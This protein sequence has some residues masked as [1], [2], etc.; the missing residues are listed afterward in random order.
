[1]LSV[2][3]TC[4]WC[5]THVFSTNDSLKNIEERL[6]RSLNVDNNDETTV[7]FN[8]KNMERMLEKA[9]LKII[10]GNLS[11]GDMLLLKS[12]NY[13]LEEVLA[14]REREL[15]KKIDDDLQNRHKIKPK[16]KLSRNNNHTNVKKIKKSKIKKSDDQIFDID[17]YNRQAVY[18]Y[19]NLANKME[20]DS[21]LSRN[22][23]ED[24]YENEK[25]TNENNNNKNDEE[26]IHLNFDR[27]MKPHIIFKIRYE[28]LDLNSNTTELS[29]EHLDTTTIATST[30]EIDLSNPLL[31]STSTT[32]N[33]N[34]NKNTFQ[35]TTDSTSSFPL[36]Y[37]WTTTS[38]SLNNNENTT[39]IDSSEL[40]SLN[41]TDQLTTTEVSVINNIKNE[42]IMKIQKDKKLNNKRVSEYEGLEWI[43]DD[44]YRVIP[45]ALNDET[46]SEVNNNNNNYDEQ[47]STTDEMMTNDDNYNSSISNDN[48]RNV[49]QEDLPQ[50]E[51]DHSRNEN[52][53]GNLTS[54]QQLTL[55]HRRDGSKWC[56]L[57]GGF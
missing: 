30:T 46:I 27:A 9:I 53:F 21:K 13:T 54:Y 32:T 51:L 35:Y 17:A 16:S 50:V 10:M 38:V 25:N 48:N 43:E 36:P 15:A 56:S 28:D 24:P 42:T 49:Y 40:L 39:I 4:V 57:L 47:L 45:E 18:D 7:P 6:R 14:I 26:N 22:D 52:S 19:E 34:Y 31:I 23:Y 11:T 20:E 41:N 29:N 55:A 2:V 3:T 8:P 33:G 5:R 12:L 1:M 37:K 44:V